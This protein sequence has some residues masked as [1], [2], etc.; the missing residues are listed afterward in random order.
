MEQQNFI[1][2]VLRIKDKSEGL[3]NCMVNKINNL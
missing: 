1:T 3:S 2:N